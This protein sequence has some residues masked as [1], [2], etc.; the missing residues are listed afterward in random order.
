MLRAWLVCVVLAAA[1]VAMGAEATRRSLAEFGDLSTVKSSAAALQKGIDELL[2]TGGGVLEIPANA[3]DKLIVHNEIQKKIDEP[4]VTIVDYRRGYTKTLLPSIGRHQTCVWAGTRLER[5]LNLGQNSLPHCGIYSNQTIQ[6][7]MISGASSY[8]TTLTEPVKAGKDV[9]CY[10]DTI[11]GIWVGQ[12]LNITGKPMSYAQPYD[13]ITVKGIGW[14]RERRRNF[15]TVDLK[16]DHPAGAIVY[17]KHVVNGLQVEGYSNCDNQSMELQVTRRHYAV[18]DSFVISGM[19]F[20]M[21]D[22]FSGFGDEGAIV[23]NAETVG[24]INGFH[25]T[26]E[27]VDWSKDEITYAPGVANPHTLSNSRPLISMNR[28]K[29][30]TA[31]TVLIVAP[32]GTYKGKSYPSVIGGVANVFNYQGGLPGRA[33]PRYGGLPLDARRGR[34]LLRPDRPLRDHRGERQV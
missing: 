7:Y 6:N 29:W 14:D 10:V 27:G 32:G 20:Y 5:R 12:F 34:P 16:H 26:V 18:G 8:M 15:F 13:R 25:S 2:R 22:V 3:P 21:G 17:N 9:R 4:T 23:L 1:S 30:I 33:D 11:R 24:E 31:G 19:L 28:K